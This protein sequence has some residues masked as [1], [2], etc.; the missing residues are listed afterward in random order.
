[1]NHS[2]SMQFGISCFITK[3]HPQQQS[4]YLDLI[5]KFLNFQAAFQC[6]VLIRI[7]TKIG[8]TRICKCR[9][10]QTPDVFKCWVWFKPFY[11]W[12]KK[13]SL[14]CKECWNDYK[15]LVVKCYLI[16]LEYWGSQKLWTESSYSRF[17]V[18]ER[19]MCLFACYVKKKKKSLFFP[20]PIFCK[21]IKRKLENSSVT[22]STTLMCTYSG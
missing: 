6:S 20:Y 3:K 17:P 9:H 22:V 2:S 19:G 12:W 21:L 1:M 10:L 14:L 18:S 5:S 8:L 16:L 15:I 4:S 7:T 13:K 11:I